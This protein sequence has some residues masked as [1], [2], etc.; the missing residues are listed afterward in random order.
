MAD[1][2]LMFLVTRRRHKV[3]VQVIF[4]KKT[5]KLAFGT[6]QQFILKKI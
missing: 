2:V 1:D 3:V 4:L 5:S 6:E